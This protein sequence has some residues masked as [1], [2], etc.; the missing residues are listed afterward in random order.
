VAFIAAITG[1]ALFTS[2][3]V[4]YTHNTAFQLKMTM[5]A[6]AGINMVVFQLI[7]FRS[8]GGW[9]EARATPVGARFAGA[10]SLLAWISIVACGRWIGFTIGF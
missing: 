9:D 6:L 3:A 4:E 5:M 7:T 8:V 2:N 10:F 1:S